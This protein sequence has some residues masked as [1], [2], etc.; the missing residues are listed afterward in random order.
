MYLPLETTFAIFLGGCIKGIVEMLGKKK[1]L[2]EAQKIRVENSGVLVAAGLIAGEALVG[3]LFAGLA[4]GKINF[5]II[6]NPGMFFIS[7]IIL[8][9]IALILIFVPLRDPGPAD[10]PA[11]P[12]A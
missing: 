10:A 6:K 5:T 11:P 3:L 8:A 1:G 7:L 9:V 2:T 12:K 4:V